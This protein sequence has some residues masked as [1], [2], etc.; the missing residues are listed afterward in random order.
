MK[1]FFIVR[2]PLVSTIQIAL[3]PNAL[4][5]TPMLS[6]P[7]DNIIKPVHPSVATFVGW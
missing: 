5:S 7:Q 3:N 6:Q 1:K 4:C 2:F